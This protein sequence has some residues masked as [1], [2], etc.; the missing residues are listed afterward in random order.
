VR[1]IAAE[2]SMKIGRFGPRLLVF[3]GSGRGAAGTRARG[4]GA[5]GPPPQ[6]RSLVRQPPEDKLFLQWTIIMGSHV[7]G[8]RDR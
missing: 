6:F 8:F 5:P 3:A 7:H 2:D 4:V 1:R